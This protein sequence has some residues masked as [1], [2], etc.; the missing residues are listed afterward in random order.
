MNALVRWIPQ[1]FGERFKQGGLLWLLPELDLT[2]VSVRTQGRL[3][4]TP[5]QFLAVTQAHELAE[6]ALAVSRGLRRPALARQRHPGG[7]PR[8]Y[9]DATVLLMAIVQT[10]WRKSYSQIVDWVYCDQA[11]AAA[12]GFSQKGGRIQTISQGQYWQRRMQLGLAPFVFFF[13]G[14]VGLLIRLGVIQGSQLIVD[15]TRLKAWRQNDPDAT[16]IKYGRQPALLG[17]K[18]HTVLC[19]HAELPV[20]LLVT[21]A[22]IRD[23]VAGAVAVFLAALLFP[24]RILVVYADAAYFERRFFH[25]V[26][27]ILG[28]HPAVNYNL[29]RAGKRKLALPFFIDQWRRLVLT[30]RQAIE[31][32]FAWLKRY[33][34]LADFQGCS[35]FRV[36]QYVLTVYIAVLLLALAAYR[37]QRPELMHSRSMVIAQF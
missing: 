34:G 29:R 3:R 23:A 6:W 2:P 15:S 12:L 25:V 27:D 24:L 32:H 37:C 9:T 13:L 20:F 21:P 16:W 7:R 17:Y 8:E 33:F 18:V 4:L 1:C 19:R 36:A 10:L 22:H 30:P 11:L 26:F 5:Q 14:L 31:R 35:Q 28:A